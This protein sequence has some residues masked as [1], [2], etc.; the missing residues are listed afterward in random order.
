MRTNQ[1]LIRVV[2]AFIRGLISYGPLT[3]GNST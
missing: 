1:N 2:F 3:T